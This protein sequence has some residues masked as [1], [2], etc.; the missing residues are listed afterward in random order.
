MAETKQYVVRP[1]L[2]KNPLKLSFIFEGEGKRRVVALGGRI[3]VK[4]KPPRLTEVIEPVKAQ[5]ELKQLYE[6]GYSKY[7]DLK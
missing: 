7:I 3:E 1:E 6:A 4:R 2:S 5:K